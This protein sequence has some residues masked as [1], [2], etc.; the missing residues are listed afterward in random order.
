MDYCGSLLKFC[1]Y[2]AAVLEGNYGQDFPC[3]NCF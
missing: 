1:F 3:G 2:K